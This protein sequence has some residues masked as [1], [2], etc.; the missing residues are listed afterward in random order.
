[1][2]VYQ[3]RAELAACSPFEHGIVAKRYA[4]TVNHNF[5]I[6]RDFVKILKVIAEFDIAVLAFCCHALPL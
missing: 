1:M 3:E 4:H 6:L 2:S 5:D